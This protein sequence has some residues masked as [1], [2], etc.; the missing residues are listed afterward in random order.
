MKGGF[1]GGE[2]LPSNKSRS[3]NSLL[4]GTVSWDGIFK[5]QTRGLGTEM[6]PQRRPF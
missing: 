4:T 3:A 6:R 2:M 1:P 5:A